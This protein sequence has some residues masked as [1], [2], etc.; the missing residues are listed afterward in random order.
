MTRRLRPLL[1]LFRT[2]VLVLLALGVVAKPILGELCDAHALVHLIAREAAKNDARHQHVDTAAE[3]RSDRDHAS[4]ADQSLHAS[5]ASP[6]F[7]EVFPALTVP[8]AHFA[9]VALPS[10]VAP[11]FIV[12]ALDSPLRPPIA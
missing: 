5:D 7:V 10:H 1:P 12:R 6:A 11:S 2:L 3:A 4:G 9:S 8:P